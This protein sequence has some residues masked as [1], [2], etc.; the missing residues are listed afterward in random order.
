MSI[1]STRLL[2][3]CAYALRELLAPS[4]LIDII[5]FGFQLILVLAV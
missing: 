5:L 3:E 2:C 4:H 1:Y